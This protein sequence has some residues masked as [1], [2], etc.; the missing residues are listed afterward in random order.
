MLGSFLWSREKQATTIHQEEAQLPSRSQSKA[1]PT[2]LDLLHE[3]RA[4]QSI[5]SQ[6][7]VSRS[8]RFAFLDGKPRH[9]VGP[10]K[11]SL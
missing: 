2:T 11:I 9:K 4:K 1:L 10:R 5:L 8:K 6:Q 3:D 7:W